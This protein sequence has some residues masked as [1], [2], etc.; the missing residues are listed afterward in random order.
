MKTAYTFDESVVV[1]RM[2]RIQ[3]YNK[4]NAYWTGRGNLNE[5]KNAFIISKKEFEEDCVI[6]KNN[7]I[8]VYFIRR[9][10]QFKLEW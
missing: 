3:T 1:L 5:R 6:I 2:K 8:S 4:F 10:N 7:E 9:V